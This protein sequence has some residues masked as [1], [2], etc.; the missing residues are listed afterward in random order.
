MMNRIVLDHYTTN[1]SFS[2]EQVPLDVVVFI[3][4]VW[5]LSKIPC[6]VWKQE[7]MVWDKPQYPTWLFWCRDSGFVESRCQNYLMRYCGFTRLP[8]VLAIRDDKFV[9]QNHFATWS[10]H[11][12]EQHQQCRWHLLTGS[13]SS[14]GQAFVN[15]RWRQDLLETTQQLGLQNDY[16]SNTIFVTC[17]SSATNMESWKQLR[18]MICNSP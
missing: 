16:G 1:I 3:L 4:W 8:W 13:G 12:P 10:V 9:A 18:D 7:P 17:C 14:W 15:S 2:V 5:L 11:L 6:V